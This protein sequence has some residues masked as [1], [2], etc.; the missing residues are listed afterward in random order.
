MKNSVSL[1]SLGLSLFLSLC[2]SLSHCDTCQNETSPIHPMM[3]A[4]HNEF[5]ATVVAARNTSDGASVEYP[6]PTSMKKPNASR[7]AYDGSHN[8]YVDQ[9]RV[10]YRNTFCLA[11]IGRLLLRT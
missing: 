6:L 9:M 10:Q 4:E 3:R 1:D 5:C 2:L 11:A 7:F 8:A